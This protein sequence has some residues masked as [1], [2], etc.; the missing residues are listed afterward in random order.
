MQEGMRFIIINVD[1]SPPPVQDNNDSNNN[2]NSQIAD[3]STITDTKS[4]RTISKVFSEENIEDTRTIRRHDK[5]GKKI[6]LV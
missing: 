1:D 6:D 2:N 5:K 4:A 3:D